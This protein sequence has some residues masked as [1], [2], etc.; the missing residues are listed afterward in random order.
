MELKARFGTN[1]D[2]VENGV[3]VPLQRDPESGE[4]L[5]AVKIARHN[6]KR[7]RRHIQ[8]GMSKGRETTAKELEDLLIDGMAQYVIRD[9]KG[10]TEN[11][12]D[13]PYSVEAAIKILKDPTLGDFRDWVS[14]ESMKMEN[15]KLKEED[16]DSGKSSATS[17]QSGSGVAGESG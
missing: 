15:Y 5:A 7:Y 11:G 16:D 6:N 4:V 9:W 3:W 17:E 13:L 8:E 12:E 2:S 10:I 1:P 14:E